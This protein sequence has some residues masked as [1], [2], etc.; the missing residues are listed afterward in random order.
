MTESTVNPPSCSFVEAASIV[1]IDSHTERASLP[2]WMRSLKLAAQS[3]TRPRSALSSCGLPS[4]L[5]G[6]RGGTKMCLIAYSRSSPSPCE[7]VVLDRKYLGI[8]IPCSAS[9]VSGGTQDG[10]VGISI[11]PRSSSRTR[12]WTGTLRLLLALS[13]LRSLPYRLDAVREQHG[14]KKVV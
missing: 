12:N 13:S 9:G 10:R 14:A 3:L 5:F 7:R 6:S 11:L 4:A 1:Y 2:C 8:V